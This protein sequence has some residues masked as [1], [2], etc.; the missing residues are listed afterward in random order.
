MNLYINTSGKLC[1]IALLN[2]ETVVD[3]MVH[4]QVMQH[5]T[6]LHDMITDIL[7]KSNTTFSE[8]KCVCVLNGPGSY[9]GLRVGLAAAKSICYSLEIPLI[10]FNQLELC[11]EYYI[12]STDTTLAVASIMPARAGEFFFCL[13][14][15]SEYPIEASVYE[16]EIIKEILEKDY[17]SHVLLSPINESKE[18]VPFLHKNLDLPLKFISEQL[19]KRLKSNDLNNIYSAE[20]FY[21]KK[22][23]VNA[24]KKR[25]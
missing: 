11:C 18:E 19:Y 24:P 7:R 5:S 12:H 15:S 3:H 25:F 13:K 10:L 9:T 22:V 17:S 6:V 21:L 20:P 4:E 23:H 14:K 1:E 2:N 16:T 8:I